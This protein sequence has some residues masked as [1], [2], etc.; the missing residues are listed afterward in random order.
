MD[1]YI[2]RFQ[3]YLRQRNFSYSPGIIESTSSIS[4]VIWKNREHKYIITFHAPTER[5]YSYGRAFIA[6]PPLGRPEFEYSLNVGTR[7]HERRGFY[8]MLDSLSDT[9]YTAQLRYQHRLRSHF[10]RYSSVVDVDYTRG[11]GLL[12]FRLRHPLTNMEFSVSINP[13]SGAIMG[14]G[15][16]AMY[17]GTIDNSGSASEAISINQFLHSLI[18]ANRIHAAPKE[19]RTVVVNWRKEGF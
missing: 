15:P 17:S 6:F 7:Y 16:R 5:T 14:S 9:R 18:A 1:D 10:D 11:G 3:S 2:V 13:D 8:A 12:W 4:M 19:E